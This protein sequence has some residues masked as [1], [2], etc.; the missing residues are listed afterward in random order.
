MRENELEV[1]R[2]RIR[3]LYPK[4]KMPTKGSRMAAGHDIY[5]IEAIRIPAQG[6][7]LVERGICGRT[8]A[9]YLRTTGTKKRASKQKGNRH[10]R[11]SN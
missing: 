2:L 1:G 5:A 7:V 11:G 4:A 6:Q 10:W 9:K 8:T 3:R